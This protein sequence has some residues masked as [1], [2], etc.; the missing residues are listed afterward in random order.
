M[1]LIEKTEARIDRFDARLLEG[2]AGEKNTLAL[3][4]TLPGV[5]LIGAAM[6]LVEIDTDMV[7]FCSADRLAFWVG[8]CPGNNG[9]L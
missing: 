1:H 3:L 6:Q 9:L 4:Q 7:D 5:D 8:I 2:L